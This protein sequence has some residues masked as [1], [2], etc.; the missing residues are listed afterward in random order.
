MAQGELQFTVI[1]ITW[2]MR[3]QIRVLLVTAWILARFLVL[4]RRVMFTVAVKVI[5]LPCWRPGH[6]RCLAW[7]RVAKPADGDH[8]MRF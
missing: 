8:V 5:P 2:V 1:T 4:R 7:L 6:I 3:L